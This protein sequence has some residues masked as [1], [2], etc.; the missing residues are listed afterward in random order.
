MLFI[1]PRLNFT[2]KCERCGLRS[3]IA[4]PYCTHCNH[5][6]DRELATLKIQHANERKAAANV[7]VSFIFA[8]IFLVFILFVLV[9][10]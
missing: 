9:R 8:A 2:K 6:T 4:K 3:L 10:V 1:P 7:G 5:L